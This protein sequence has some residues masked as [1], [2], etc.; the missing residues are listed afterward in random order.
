MRIGLGYESD[1]TDFEKLDPSPIMTRLI[2]KIKKQMAPDY[3]AKK[4]NV[5]D[6]EPEIG[7]LK[8]K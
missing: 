5:I 8:L 1:E 6:F 7:K 3:L 2:N 4:R